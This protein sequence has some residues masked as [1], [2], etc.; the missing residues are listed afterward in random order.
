MAKRSKRKKSPREVPATDG[1][2]RTIAG[3]SRDWLLALLLFAAVA[4]AYFPLWRAGYVW[5]DDLMLTANPCIVGPLGLLQI[6]T[7]SQA[8]ICPLTLTTIWAM[9]KIWGLDPLPYHLVNVVLHGLSAIVLWHVLRRLMVPGA[10]LGAALWAIHPVQVESVAWVAELK[11]VQSGFF[12]LLSASFFLRSLAPDGAEANRIKWNYALALIFAG[13]AMASK[14]STVILPVALCLCAWWMEGRWQWRT[15]ARTAPIFMMS[16]VAGLVSI[17]T[18][19]L[20]SLAANDLPAPRSWLE[21]LAEAGDAFWFYLGKL[22]W[23][24]P[25]ATI[26]PRWAVDPAQFESYLLLLG[27]VVIFALLWFARTAWSRA[28]LFAFAYFLIA[29]LPVVGLADN[30]IFRYSLVFDHLQYLA[31]MGPLALAGAALARFLKVLAPGSFALRAACCTCVLVLVGTLTSL[32]ARIYQNSATLWADA[33]AENPTAWIAHS[34]YAQALASGGQFSEA[35]PHFEMAL[36]SEPRSAETHY[37]LGVAFAHQGRI[38]DAMAEYRTA[39]E[40][41]PSFPE[42]HAALANAL[43]QKG[44]PDEAIEQDQAVLAIRPA[45]ADAW[46]SLGTALAK[47]GR[48]TDAVPAFEKAVEL[49][50]NNSQ[51]RNNLGAAFFQLGDFEKALPEFQEAL[52][53]DP[54]NA[55]AQS[56]LEKTGAR[57]GKQGLPVH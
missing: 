31:S 52:R 40:L 29:L 55:S 19:R 46:Y 11:N 36:R 25:L 10:W 53:L 34:N 3:P 18:Q 15:L 44:N 14:S 56:N 47:K 49:D 45:F 48:F 54:Q 50:P 20:Q 1:S 35:I 51:Y 17:W 39:I 4:L 24:Y 8:D 22:I 38:D 5:D 27:V 12:F 7:T 43:L 13:C 26:Y 42:A 16:I 32:H 33:L 37:D 9:H 28:L 2:T 57:L 6:W 30:F 41:F 23:P 21:R